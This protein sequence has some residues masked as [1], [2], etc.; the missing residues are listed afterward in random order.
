M[1]AGSA[2]AAVE[3]SE[4]CRRYGRRWALVNVDLRV[5]RGRAVML[6]GRN[7]SGKTTLLRVLASA[8]RADRGRVRILGHDLPHGAPE[9]R[10]KVALLS[11]Q[12]YSY[13]CLSA[14]ENLELTASFLDRRIDRAE[15]MGRLEEVGLADRAHDPVS[16]FSAGMRKRLSLARVILQEAELVLLDEPYA[17]LDVHG[18]ALVDRTIERLRAHC[19][20]VVLATHLLEHGQGLCDEAV[21]LEEG[22]LLWAGRPAEAPLRAKDAGAGR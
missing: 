15:I 7:G 8:I 20:T 22:R 5:E 17:A 14:R 21:L 2:C 18:C 9:A 4:V 16:D 6:G 11:H 3:A 10:R 19:S 12:S 13:E 1:G